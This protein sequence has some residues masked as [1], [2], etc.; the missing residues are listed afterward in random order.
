MLWVPHNPVLVTKTYP[1]GLT[2]IINN[3]TMNNHNK[4][5]RPMKSPSQKLTYRIAIKLKTE[6][7]YTIKFN[8]KKA[9]LTKTEYVRQMAINGIVKSRITPEM[10]DCI[11]KLSGMANNLN[12]I[13]KKANS[14]GY[15]DAR[16]E[17]LHIANDIDNL[18]NNI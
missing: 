16:T 5:G 1:D 9:G 6:D 17:Y 13:A 2:K 10:L 4:R 15:N 11:R 18:L 3:F 8:A 12:Q 7:F 14:V